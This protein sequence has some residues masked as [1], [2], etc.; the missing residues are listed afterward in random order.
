M[1]RIAN[2]HRKISRNLLFLELLD[3]KQ[4]QSVKL[5]FTLLLSC[6]NR[7]EVKGRWEYSRRMSKVI[8]HLA[9]SILY[10]IFLYKQKHNTLIFTLLTTKRKL[11]AFYNF[12]R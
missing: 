2:V 5:F 9:N 6:I 8:S 11:C 4:Y 12:F 3:Q 1:K 7:Q 10:Y